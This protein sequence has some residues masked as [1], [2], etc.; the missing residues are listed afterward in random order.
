MPEFLVVRDDD[1]LNFGLSAEQGG[2]ASFN[3]FSRSGS[4][5]LLFDSQYAIEIPT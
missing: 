5:T 4:Q 3:C 2:D 1:M